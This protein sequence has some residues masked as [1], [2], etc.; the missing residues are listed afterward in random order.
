MDCVHTG[1]Q[2]PSTGPRDRSPLGYTERSETDAGYAGLISSK[3]PPC[4]PRTFPGESV[5]QNSCPKRETGTRCVMMG[6]GLLAAGRTS[7]TDWNFGWK[8]AEIEVEDLMVHG[9]SRLASQS[10]HLRPFQGW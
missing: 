6:S 8:M 7:T 3:P 4:A 10:D 1:C 9:R 5:V 2:E